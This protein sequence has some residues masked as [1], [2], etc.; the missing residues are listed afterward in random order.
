MVNWSELPY[1]LLVMIAKRVLV[2][3]DFVVFGAVCKSWRS[4]ATKENFDESL[5]QVSLLMLAADKDNDY[6]EFFSLSKKL[7]GKCVFQHKN[8]LPPHTGLDDCEP[9]YDYV[10]IDLAVLSAN[11]SLTSDYV[12][13][14]S[15]Y[16]HGSRLAFW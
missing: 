11:P 9:G 14:V 8:G 5:P 15:Y 2:M 1:D 4:T 7:K 10:I 16:G 12:L 3:E 13:M 6:R